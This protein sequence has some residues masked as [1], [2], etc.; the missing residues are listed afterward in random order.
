[1]IV[2]RYATC[3]TSV[4]CGGTLEYAVSYKA[5]GPHEADSKL[6]LKVNPCFVHKAVTP[7][8]IDKNGG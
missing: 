6:K 8:V 1:M 5:E 3:D 2:G 7:M 4:R